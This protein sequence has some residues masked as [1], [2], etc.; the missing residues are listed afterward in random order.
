METECPTTTTSFAATDLLLLVQAIR[1]WDMW[2][3]LTEPTYLIEDDPG[4]LLRE[5]IGGLHC[6]FPRPPKE[7]FVG[8]IEERYS[9]MAFELG[10]HI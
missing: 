6:G 4:R 1:A 7:I 8:D 2:A 9:Q 5:L 3:G 10:Q